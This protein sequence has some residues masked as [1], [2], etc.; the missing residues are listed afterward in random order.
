[1]VNKTKGEEPHIYIYI[2]VILKEESPRETR[3]ISLYIYGFIDFSAFLGKK[4]K[5]KCNYIHF[6]FFFAWIWNLWIFIFF[7]HF[8]QENSWKFKNLQESSWKNW[9]PKNNQSFS[10]IWQVDEIYF[11][12]KKKKNYYSLFAGWNPSFACSNKWN[13]ITRIINI[14]MI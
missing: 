2:Y 4:I 12:T 14:N 3:R 8:G 10:L 7:H 13:K 11:F 1:M 5:N 6:F 9:E